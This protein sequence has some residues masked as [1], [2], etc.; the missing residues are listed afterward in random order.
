MQYRNLIIAAIVF[1][2]IAFI[3]YYLYDYYKIPD[4]PQGDYVTELS[5]PGVNGVPVSI[6]SLKGKIVLI[7]FWASWCGPCRF[8]NPEL[9]HLYLQFHQ[10][11]FKH[12]TGFEIYS[13]SLDVS[14]ERWLNA[15][16]QDGLIWS[17]HVSDLKG[18]NSDAAQKFGVRSI[19][20][21]ILIDENGKIIGRN[22][23]PS[24]IK[25]EL[26]KRR[27]G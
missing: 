23:T 20:S 7:D 8:A 9:V 21:S 16:E 26:E 14:R 5:Y 17:S 12:A 3:T 4:S 25:H 1:V 24:E 6:A 19:P 10:D 11:Q 15:I 13:I 2:C 18:W 22:L 27:A